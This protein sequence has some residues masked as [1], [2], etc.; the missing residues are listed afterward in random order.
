MDF[1]LCFNVQNV[2]NRRASGAP[3]PVIKQSEREADHFN[4]C[5]VEESMICIYTMSQ[6]HEPGSITVPETYYR[7]ASGEYIKIN[8]LLRHY[9]K[10]VCRNES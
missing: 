3:C 9:L 7:V 10:D 2:H 8:E 4:L 5:S 1:P 6:G